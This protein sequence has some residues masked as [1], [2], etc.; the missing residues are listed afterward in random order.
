MTKTALVCGS[1]A[2]DSIMLFK[3]RFK[4][5]I[6]PDKV[7]ILNVSFHVPDMRKEF[8]GC[9]GNI[10][11]N[12][13]MLGETVLPI[14]TVGMDFEPYRQRLDKLG[15]NSSYIKTLNDAYTAQ[16]FIT[17]DRD[18]NQI[19]AFHPGAMDKA[20]INQIKYLKLNADIAIV[21]PDGKQAMIN[22]AQDLYT[23][24]IAF[25]F[26]PG[27][28]LPLFNCEQLRTFVKQANW[29]TLNDYELGM[30]SKTAAVSTAEIAKQ[31][32]ALVVTKGAKGSSIYY[33]EKRLD[34]AALKVKAVDPT[35]CGDAYRAG[36]LYGLMHNFNWRKTAQLATIIA[37][38]KLEA[39]GTQNH[40]FDLAYIKQ[41]YSK[42]YHTDL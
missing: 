11:Y 34:I 33:D 18:D 16:A 42:Y 35:G 32:Q 38:I 14:A 2:F 19:T 13:H 31:V 10:S 7:H 28:S 26:D 8:G 12:L 24:N 1:Y 23:Q 37:A 30:I 4:N 20:H 5:H 27:Q 41:Q 29:I 3:G 6:L 39:Q 25:V 15:I 22:H 36:I 21:A 40:K 9:A 17:T